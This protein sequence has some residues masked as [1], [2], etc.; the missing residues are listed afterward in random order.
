MSMKLWQLDLILRANHG[1]DRN[2][3]ITI[4]A[5]KKEWHYLEPLFRELFNCLDRNILDALLPEDFV[6]YV[7]EES[8]L[9]CYWRESDR[10]IT[11]FASD[12]R[13][14]ISALTVYL[15][16]GADVLERIVERGIAGDAGEL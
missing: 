13:E 10:T 2:L 6:V 8:S 11:S 12:E 4:A 3:P 1:R 15:Q 9:L 5:S 7:L 14:K 16:Y